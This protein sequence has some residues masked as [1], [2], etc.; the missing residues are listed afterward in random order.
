LFA[1]KRYLER[2][3]SD[4]NRGI[5]VTLP[6][7]NENSSKWVLRDKAYYQ[8]LG[9][10]YAD[11][12]A[13]E[14]P[15]QMFDNDIKDKLKQFPEMQGID[16]EKANVTYLIAE[17]FKSVHYDDVQ[18]FYAYPRNYR[19]IDLLTCETDRKNSLIKQYTET[20][21]REALW[22]ARSERVEVYKGWALRKK[23]NDRNFMRMSDSEFSS[24][25]D[26]RLSACRNDFQK[27]EKIIRRFKVQDI[28]LFLMAKDKL[29]EHLD[30]EA[31]SFKLRDISPDA[32]RGVMSEIMPI[33]FTFDKNG[34]KYT[35]HSDGMKLKNYG[36]FF[37]L[38]NDK[39]FT[40]LL[41]ILSAIYVCKEEIEEELSNYDTCRPN[42]V[43]LILE[44]EKVAFEKYPEIVAL[45][46]QFEITELSS[47]RPTTPP[48]GM[49][50]LPEDISPSTVQSIISL[51]TDFAVIIPE[52]TAE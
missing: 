12:L 41:N 31:K 25:L 9:G 30:F 19:Y 36:E 28:M 4:L 51:F 52:Q 39:R 35:I 18:E 15:R 37:A 33:D 17:Y 46:T 16:F 43:K 14:L 47:A 1:R 22:E 24:I 6:F 38:A 21:K 27:S 3:N 45:L 32:D 7:V 50:A 8:T 34:K 40:S 2:I 49:I 48:M 29:N 44:F 26:K 42:V 11:E 13:I 10:T 23:A 5:P 20:A